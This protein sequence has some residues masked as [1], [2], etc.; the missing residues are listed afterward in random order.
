MFEQNFS[1]NRYLK[2]AC[3]GEGSH[4][5]EENFL[6]RRKHCQQKRTPVRQRDSPRIT[7]F[8][9]CRGSGGLCWTDDSGPQTARWEDGL[10]LV[11]GERPVPY[12]A[13]SH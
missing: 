12:K 2:K 9:E 6:G 3:S 7:Y 8:R 4:R 11:N 5:I 10:C 13:V 1:R